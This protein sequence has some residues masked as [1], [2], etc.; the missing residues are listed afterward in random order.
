[1]SDNKASTSTPQ[2]GGGQNGQRHPIPPPPNLFTNQLHQSAP[3]S[4]G[5]TDKKLPCVELFVGDLSFFCLEQ[6]LERL[7]SPFGQI[8]EIVVSRSE[9]GRHSLLHGFIKMANLRDAE[10]AAAN[11]N[12]IPFM[13]RTLRLV[14][15][16]RESF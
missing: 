16:Y 1:M 3:R 8:L 2:S 13:G 4:K 10:A 15:Y 14:S 12:E 5:S 6:D 11:L 9:K 7:F